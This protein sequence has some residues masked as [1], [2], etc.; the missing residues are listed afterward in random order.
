MY[1]TVHTRKLRFFTSR[2]TCQN[3]MLARRN[4]PV[5]RYRRAVVIYFFVYLWFVNGAGRSSDRITS[6]NGIIR[7]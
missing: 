4:I 5:F 3:R 6:N 2:K 1:S 7:K